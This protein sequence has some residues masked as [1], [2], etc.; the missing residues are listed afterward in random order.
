MNFKQALN[1]I[2]WKFEPFVGYFAY[3]GHLCINMFMRSLYPE[4]LHSKR[5]K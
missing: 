5:D 1:E 4:D 3:G 2:R